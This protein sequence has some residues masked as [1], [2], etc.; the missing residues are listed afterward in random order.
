MT[1]EEIIIEASKLLKYG[2]Y[3][4]VVN[5]EERLT[6]II[7][8]CRKYGLEPKELKILPSTKGANVIMLK[9]KKGGNSGLTISLN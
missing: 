4:Y 3:F 6:D 2:G 9:A 7:V 8:Y 1:L 5:K